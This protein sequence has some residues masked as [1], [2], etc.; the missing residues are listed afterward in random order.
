MR[1]LSFALPAFVA[2]AVLARPSVA[3]AQ[4]VG[5]FQWSLQPYCNVITLSV[6]RVGDVFMLDGFDDNCGAA[7]RSAVTGSAIANADG[8]ISMGLTIVGSQTGVPPHVAARVSLPTLNGTWQD[9]G[10]HS[11]T[12]VP[13]TVPGGGG[14]RPAV[15]LVGPAGPTGPA[16]PQGPAGATGA[17][18]PQGATG[19]QGAPGP[20]GPAGPAAELSPVDEFFAT[21][22]VRGGVLTCS[23]TDSFPNQT[24]CYGML[25][26]G[27]HIANSVN[28]EN[29]ICAVVTGA[30]ESYGAYT[31]N[32]VAP[33]FDSTG[34]TWILGSGAAVR[35]ES[36]GCFK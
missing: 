20:Q 2:I 30:T 10:G 36:L 19:A 28:I 17:T 14:P 31:S 12:F 7:T 27:R 5:T 8:T 15:S 13:G 16:G 4:S 26:N 25:L 11:G 23:S 21:Q 18:G 24:R 33:Y 1:R 32:P 35:R 29:M 34:S 22:I 6:V 3:T 9:G